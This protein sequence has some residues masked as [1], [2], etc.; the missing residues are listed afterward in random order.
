MVK[1]K[2]LALNS[3]GMPLSLALDSGYENSSSS[4]FKNIV[5]D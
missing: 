2:M 1:M 3:N 4:F 5:V